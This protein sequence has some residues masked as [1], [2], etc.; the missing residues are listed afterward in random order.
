MLG[1][2]D[3]HQHFWELGRQFRVG[4]LPYELGTVTYAWE[5]ANSSKLN[6]SFLPSDLKDIID[7][8]DVEGTILVNVIH[9][10][11]ENIWFSELAVKA[12]F[13]KGI[14]GWV[15]LLQPASILEE[16]IMEL[17][18][19]DKFVG[20]RHLTQ[21]EKD[22][23]WLLRK[24]V[25]EGLNV[26]AKHNLKYDILVKGPQIQYIPRISEKVP[27]LYMVIDHIAKPNIKD[28]EVEPWRSYMKQAAENPK[29]FCKLSGM[30]TEADH[31]SWKI[32]DFLPYVEAVVE[33][34]G[35]DRLMFGSDWPV[36]TLA[37]TYDQVL[38]LAVDSLDRVYSGLSFETKL[39]VFRENAINF[40][41][42]K[43]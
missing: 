40:Y 28:H 42:L 9:S 38:N 41:G 34:F 30:V 2:I 4:D 23:A 43:L 17:K 5:L 27:D 21:F 7:K 16:Q 14:V 19:N 8:A 35:E 37:A 29:V 32:D 31:T 22:P 6:K 12:D 11:D 1:I 15:N 25:I 39:K 10:L 33:F 20:V 36:C 26:L 3:A 24:D 13:I 18:S